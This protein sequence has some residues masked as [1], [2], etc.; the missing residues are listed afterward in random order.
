MTKIIQI[1][2]LHLSDPDETLWGLSPHKRLM[3][4]LE[5]IASFHSDAKACVITGDLTDGASLKALLWLRQILSDFPITTYL[6]IGNHDVRSVFFEAFAYYPR[7]KN[8]FLQY[9]FD[10]AESR[11]FV[12][13]QKR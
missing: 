3:S 4:A 10:I 13:T 12:W 2:D 8:G 9:S 11:F 1:T 7:D 6:M 5:D